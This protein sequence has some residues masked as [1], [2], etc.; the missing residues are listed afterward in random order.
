MTDKVSI[1]QMFGSPEVDTFLGLPACEPGEVNAGAAILG[2]PFATPYESVGAYCA[3]GPGAIREAIAGDAGALHHVDFDH[4]EP[5]FRDGQVTAVDCGDLDLDPADSAGNRATI[6]DAVATILDRGAV[7]V[8][9]GGDDSIPIPMLQAFE[10]RSDVHILQ[11]DAHIDWR[12]EVQGENWGLSSTMRR[13]SEMGH[14]KGIVQAGRRGIGSARSADLQDALD[15]GVNF[16]SAREIAYGGT[17][18][19]IDLLPEGA[20]IVVA[21]D[22]DAFDPS[23]VPGV[24]G[25]SPGGLTYWQVIELIE[26]AARR[27]RIAAFDIVEYV[28][29]RDVDGLGGLVAARAVANVLAAIA[30]A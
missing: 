26:G 29:E 25:R 18:P 5:I 28:P 19:V 21:L 6:R 14:V 17:A 22:V 2:V 24:I 10:G 30:R 4:G 9:L 20:D 7:P 15:W 11:I 27:G 1:G 3:S 23:L 12:D 8:L 13:A 16:V